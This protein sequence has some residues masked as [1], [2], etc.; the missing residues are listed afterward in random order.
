MIPAKKLLIVVLGL[1][2]FHSMATAQKVDLFKMQDDDDKKDVKKKTDYTTAI[3]KTTRLVNGQTI[4]NVGE[5]VLDFRINHRFGT[6]NSGG[7]NL[8]G[9]DQASM[10]I[11]LDYGISKKLMVGIGRSTYLK[12]YDGFVKYKLLRQ[13]TGKVNMPL[14]VS[15]AGGVILKTIDENNPSGIKYKYSDRF[16]YF[17]QLILARKFN[18]YFSLQIVPTVV[19]YNSVA[20]TKDPNDLFSLGFGTRVRISRRVNITS[21]YYYQFKK[22]EGYYNSLSF[23]VD[24]E[25]GGHVFQLHLTNSTGMTERTFINENTGRWSKGDIHLGFNISRVF[26]IKK[27]KSIK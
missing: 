25:T 12:Q 4:E 1:L 9:L 19:H 23:G 3:F 10:R 5:G 16:S 2:S 17:H 21:E 13:S 11:G 15:Y 7:Y 27:M 22:F 24:I 8:W 26:T 14:S 20:M 6:L 18:D